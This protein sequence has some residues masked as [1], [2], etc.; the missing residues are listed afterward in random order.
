MDYWKGK[1]QPPFN[2][3]LGMNIEEWR[4]GFVKISAEVLPHFQNS[5]GAPHGGF[6][7]SM[8]DIAASFP[9]VYCPHAD[10]RRF[11]STLSLNTNFLGVA[12]TPVIFA[13]GRVTTSG[14]KIFYSQVDIYDAD[15][16]PV[17]S[18]QGVFRYRGGSENIDGVPIEA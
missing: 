11:A 18:C 13:E 9:G 5:Q 1:P 10:R 2:D 4:E 6:I 8:A 17:A 7:M 12:K 15:K 3:H 14:R 16:N